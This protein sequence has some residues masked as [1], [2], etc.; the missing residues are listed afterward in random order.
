MIRVVGYYKGSMRPQ[1]FCFWV[2][3]RLYCKGSGSSFHGSLIVNAGGCT[4]SLGFG[5][6]GTVRVL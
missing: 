5:V 2:A 1:G 4:V 6:Q 3:L